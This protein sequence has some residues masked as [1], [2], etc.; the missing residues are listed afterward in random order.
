MRGSIDWQTAELVKVL[1]V[2]GAK[3][4]ERVDHTHPNF[5]CV[6]SFKTMETYR[7][8][9]NN[10]GFYIKQY[11]S[12]KDFEEITGEHVEAYMLFKL[13]DYPSRSYLS[14]ISSAL[15]KLEV[16]LKRYTLKKYGEPRHYNF[17]MRQL[18]LTMAKSLNWVYDGYHSRVYTDPE[19]LIAMLANHKH[20]CAARV[21]LHGLT[22]AEGCTLIRTE[23]LH[24]YHID[25]ISK[26]KIGVIQTKEKGG[27]VGDVFVDVDTYRQIEDI[28][29]QEG[30]FKIN[31]KS[32]AEDIRNA[33]TILQIECHGSH[34]FR[35]TAAQRR[36][37]EYQRAWYTYEEALQGVSW[38][39]KH[40]RSSITEHY[41]G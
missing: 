11:W 19:Q 8:V 2:Q 36:V 14:K 12:I 6:A 9:W 28:I 7:S 3:K 34:G 16:A 27:K 25:P 32:Y 17:Q 5:Q 30:R 35:W 21:Q 23:Q 26:K 13:E 1:F 22:R 31:Y 40:F 33:C 39:M 15:G 18:H 24:G 38:E 29:N 37:R 41:L 20:G 10:F 4:E